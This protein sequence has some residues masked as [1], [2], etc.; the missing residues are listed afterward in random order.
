VQSAEEVINA[1]KRIPNRLGIG[2]IHLKEVGFAASLADFSL[3]FQPALFI[4][5]KESD[6]CAFPREKVGGCPTDAAP[7]SGDCGYFVLQFHRG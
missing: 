4:D 6:S 1:T 2:N 3:D 7:G 5:F